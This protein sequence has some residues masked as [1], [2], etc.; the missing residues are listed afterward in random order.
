ME[1]QYDGYVVDFDIFSMNG[2]DWDLI[3][4]GQVKSDEC[5]DWG[6]GKPT[7]IHFCGEKDC[8]LFVYAY[9]AAFQLLKEYWESKVC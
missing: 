9:R 7:M 6:Y 4:E 5:C 1:V 2:N 3:V 8:F